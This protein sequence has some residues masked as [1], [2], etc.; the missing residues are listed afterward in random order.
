MKTD[1]QSS[2]FKRFWNELE[3]IFFGDIASK[4]KEDASCCKKLAIALG[5]IVIL[6][7]PVT[8]IWGN[9]VMT[10]EFL[11]NLLPCALCI[12]ALYIL[13]LMIRAFALMVEN[14][15]FSANELSVDAEIIDRLLD[16]LW[17]EAFPPSSSDNPTDSDHPTD[18]E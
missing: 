11:G 9:E 10:S 4:L 13:S 5:V 12:G 8:A 6:L 2:W 7:F 1:K 15:Q 3:D 16:Q 18:A 17:N 14:A